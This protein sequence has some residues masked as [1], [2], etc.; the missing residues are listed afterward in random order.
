MVIVGATIVD[1]N[2]LEE[3]SVGAL[4]AAPLLLGYKLSHHSPEGVTSGYIVE[5]EAYTQ[6]DPASHTYK[7]ETIRNGAMFKRSGTIYIYFTYGMHYCMNIVAS[8]PDRGEALLI[9]ALEP[10]EGIELMKLRRGID[11]ERQLTNGPAK[12]VQAMG[13]T[14]ELNNTLILDGPL[15]LEPGFTPEHIERSPRIGIK[16][17]TELP[18]RFTVADNSFVSGRLLK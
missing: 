18:W 3:L 17:A 2:I 12:L 6:D 14:K 15:R 7:G 16:R 8:V 1:M 5:V 10:V 11:D 13:V 4:H 9:R